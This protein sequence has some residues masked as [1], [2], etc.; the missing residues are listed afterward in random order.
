M[1]GFL[2]VHAEYRT[3]VGSS[4]FPEV[5][6]YDRCSL[7]RVALHR[8]INLQSFCCE[9]GTGGG[10]RTVLPSGVFGRI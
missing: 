8:F 1:P 7:T 6:P 2:E 10:R 9:G 4:R 3:N 5:V